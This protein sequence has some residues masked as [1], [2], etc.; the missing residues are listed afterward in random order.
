MVFARSNAWSHQRS[1][2]WGVDGLPHVECEGSVHE[3]TIAD[4][5]PLGSIDELLLRKAMAFIF[6]ECE[7]GA[8]SMIH[9]DVARD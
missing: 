7:R 4:T 5:A 6:V 9:H 8:A 3:T 2:A 1:V